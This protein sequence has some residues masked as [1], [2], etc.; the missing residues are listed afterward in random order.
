MIL[1]D[2]L[3]LKKKI[4]LA[5]RM[6]QK[7]VD[8]ESWLSVLPWRC[9]CSFFFFSFSFLAMI[10]AAERYI[11]TVKWSAEISRVPPFR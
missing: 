5:I 2:I 4:S 1:L 6:F 11:R 10:K 7:R 9:Y 8:N 3:K